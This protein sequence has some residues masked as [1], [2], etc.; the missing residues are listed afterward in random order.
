MSE[1][2]HSEKDENDP[3]NQAGN[4]ADVVEKKEKKRL[5][6]ELDV[7]GNE[8]HPRNNIDYSR[9]TSLFL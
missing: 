3:E 9:T 7:K 1:K 2:D 4:G 8:E 5:R 6:V